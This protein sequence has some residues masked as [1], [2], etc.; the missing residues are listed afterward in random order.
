MKSKPILVMV[1]IVLSGTSYSMA[2]TWTTLDYP[3]ADKTRAYGNDG[4]NIVGTYNDHHGFLYDGTSWTT[5]DM[6]GAFYTLAFGIDG[7]NIV[8]YYTPRRI[9]HHGFVYDGIDW[10]TLDYPGAEMSRAYGIDE[11]NIVGNYSDSSGYHGF[12]YNG[13]DWTTLDYPEAGSTWAFDIFGDNIV[14]YYW[15]MNDKHGFLYNG[16]DWTTLDYPGADETHIYGIDGNNIVGTYYDSSGYHGFLY[17]GTD[18]IMLD[19]PGA[20]ETHV[21]GIDGNNIVG[22]YYNG[23]EH[24]FIYTLTEPVTPPVADADG[25]YTI[26]I[27]DTLTLDASGSMEDDNDIVSYMWDLDDDGSFETDAGGEA[28]FDV[29]YAYLQS[30]GLLVDHIYNIHVKVTD[31][32]GQSDV[33]D[34]T[35]TII[36]KPALAVT[37]DIRPRSC[38]N[39]VNVKSKGVLPIAIL[40]TDDYDVTTV[41]PTSVRLAGV[42]PIRSGYED[43]ATPIADVNDCNCIEAGPDGFLDLTLKFETQ[44]IVATLG[45]VNHDDV[46]TLQL[47]G[48]LYDPI[49]YENPIEGADCILIKG[50]HRAHNKADINKD[51]VVNAADFAIFAQ[52]WLQSSI[53]DE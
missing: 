13:I 5:L 27:G 38:P 19:Y 42:E 14:G 45:D 1:M 39:P 8:G 37:V 10:T 48:V 18:W 41:D 9:H 32:Q 21:Y 17:N 50:R 51:G 44:D 47:T 16:I 30:L 40:G 53:V 52:N 2:G 28:V 49:P 25:P 36:P 12:L 11:D 29:N 4:K 20:D 24:G 26:Y 6:L 46:L 22:Y 34:S 23:K 35:L 31:R 33:A 7:D 3:G 43:V 15:V